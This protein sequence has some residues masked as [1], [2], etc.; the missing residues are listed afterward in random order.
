M[1]FNLDVMI[2]YF[3]NA[4]VPN[5]MYVWAIVAIGLCAYAL[6]KAR[7]MVSEI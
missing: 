7:K 1:G 4:L 6:Y 2:D 5:L 3:A